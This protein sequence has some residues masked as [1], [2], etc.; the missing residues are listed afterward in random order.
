MQDFLDEV[1]EKEIKTFTVAGGIKGWVAQ[2]GSRQM[3]WYEAAP[4][5]QQSK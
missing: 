4:W 2:Y 3:E 1:G 5:E